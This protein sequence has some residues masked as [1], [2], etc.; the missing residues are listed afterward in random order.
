MVRHPIARKIKDP[1]AETVYALEWRD[2]TNGP[3]LAS[4]D[5]IATSTW[6]IDGDDSSLTNEVDS[7]NSDSRATI[8]VSAGTAGLVYTLT[9]RIT[10]ATGEKL[11]LSFEVIMEQK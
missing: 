1:D 8:K 10:T 5:T 2:E 9:N 6:I 3:H 4:G 11:D 7:H